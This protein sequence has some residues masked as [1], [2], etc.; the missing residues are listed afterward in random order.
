MDSSNHTNTKAVSCW[1][2]PELLPEQFEHIRTL[3]DAMDEQCK[4]VHRADEIMEGNLGM[5]AYAGDNES[6][7]EQEL[8][9]IRRETEKFA[10]K[11]HK[12]YL[13]KN[14]IGQSL[15][16]EID[17]F[18]KD[19]SQNI[20]DAHGKPFVPLPQFVVVPPGTV[21]K[22]NVPWALGVRVA[23]NYV[24]HKSQWKEDA[25]QFL[26]ASGREPELADFD[27]KAQ[28]SLTVLCDLVPPCNI[29]DLVK[30]DC[31]FT[32]ASRLRLTSPDLCIRLFDEW[33]AKVIR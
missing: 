11:S 30:Y 23:G 15:I 20:N 5:L 19:V 6:L 14:V 1:Y 32:I 2:S 31:S 17:R 8:A 18:I 25:A 3:W 27:A 24:R 4:S 26:S 29:A 16:I 21:V 7:S 10:K 22:E 28:G 12:A 13:A 33:K 9:I